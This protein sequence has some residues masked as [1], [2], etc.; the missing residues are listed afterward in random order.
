MICRISKFEISQLSDFMN[1]I[2]NNH[3]ISP[4][5]I[6]QKDIIAILYDIC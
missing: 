3:V 1:F 2:L 6:Y 5:K 4:K